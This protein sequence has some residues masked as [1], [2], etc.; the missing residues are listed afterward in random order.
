MNKLF[1]VQN[2][3]FQ[4]HRKDAQSKPIIYYT[5]IVQPPFKSK[6]K[7]ILNSLYIHIK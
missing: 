5:G 3:G 6:R 4:K 7:D 2:N 1:G